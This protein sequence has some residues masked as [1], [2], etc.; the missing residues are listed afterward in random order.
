MR[1]L[2][3]ITCWMLLLIGGADA[4]ERPREITWQDLIAPVAAEIDDPFAELTGEQLMRLAQVARIRQLIES[5]RIPAYG[6]SAG[7]EKRF[8]AELEEQGIDVDWLLSQRERVTRER[9]E[10]AEQVDQQLLDTPVRIPGYTLPLTSNDD[11][12]VTGLLLVPWVGACIHTPP[13]PPNQMIHV[14]VPGGTDYRGQFAAVWIEGALEHKPASHRLFLVDGT[15]ELQVTYAMTARGIHDYSPGQSNSLAQVKIPE[16]A[17]K[18]HGWW[19]NLQTRVSIH[20]TQTMTAIRDRKSSGPLWIGLL[21]AF[22]Y[23][24]VHTLGPGHGKAVVASYFVGEGGSFGRGVRMGVQIAVFHVLSAIVVVWL[25]D[26]AVRQTTGS[27]ASDFRMV[28]LVSYGGIAAIGAFMLWRALRGLRHHHSHHEHGHEDGGE[29]HHH[30]HDCAACRCAEAKPRGASGWLALAVGAVPCTGALLVLL[31]GLANDL[32]GPAI[33]MV[34]AISA[35]MALAMSAIGVVAIFSRNLLD[36]KFDASGT[37]G[38][39]FANSAR[40]A[41]AAMVMMIGM[42]LFGWAWASDDTAPLAARAKGEFGPAP[43]A[44]AP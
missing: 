43:R 21:I 22:A 35:G 44:M 32:V 14:T 15:R 42:A 13:P 4:E 27:G 18:G 5:E 1:G 37:G 28:R 6:S 30:H 33:L 2:A 39:R 38:R 12:K 3:F 19:V 24:V 34:V 23:G 25:T 10:R 9:K 31:F 11:G 16:E 29:H 20:F 40:I 26:F 7:D 36:R 8:V 17:M 41:A